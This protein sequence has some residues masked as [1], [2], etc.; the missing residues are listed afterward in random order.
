[1]TTSILD[2]FKVIPAERPPI[3]FDIPIYVN[4]DDKVKHFISEFRTS[5]KRTI[6]KTPI[7][8]DI[9]VVLELGEQ[10]LKSK[11]PLV[12]ITNVEPKKRDKAPAR[13]SLLTHM[14]FDE[15]LMQKYSYYT[16]KAA[17]KIHPMYLNNRINFINEIRRQMSTIQFDDDDD[18]GCFS[19]QKTS[20]KAMVHQLIVQRYLNSYTPYRGLLL[21]HG[22]GSGKTCSSISL[23][24]G[25]YNSKQIFIVTPASLQANY[26]TQMKFCGEQIF[27][28]NNHWVFEKIDSLDKKRSIYTLLNINTSSKKTDKFESFI[29]KHK[30][31]WMVDVEKEPNFDSLS[32]QNRELIDQQIELMI[33]AKY[34]YINYNGITRKSWTEKYKT[35]PDIN[36][37]DNSTIIIDEA[38]NFVSRIINKINKNGKSISTDLYEEILSA[39]NCRVVLLT[40][41]PFI[42][43]PSELG[44]LFNLINGYIYSM[45]VKLSI[46]NAKVKIDYFEKLFSDQKMIDIIEYNQNSSTLKIVKNPY[47]FIKTTDGK[48]IYNTDGNIYFKDFTQRIIDILKTKPED[49]SITKTSLTK[50]K[51]LPDTMKEF[52]SYFIKSDNTINNKEFF[53]RRIVGM[54]S[55][56][57]DKKELMP[58][59]EKT[60]KNED[61]FLESIVMSPHQLKTYAKIRE[62]ERKR[63]REQRGK[64]ESSS[65]YRVFSRLACN[66]AFPEEMPRPL[67]KGGKMDESAIDAA[68]EEELLNDADGKFDEEDVKNR[69]KTTL[70]IEYEQNIKYVLDEFQQ[71][72]EKYFE[73]GIQKYI[74]KPPSPPVLQ[75]YSPK[76]MEIL[77]N[78]MNPDPEFIGCHLLYSNFRKLEGIG[79]F[80][81]ILLYHGYRELKVVKNGTTLSLELIGMYN[82]DS[83]TD[84]K[85][86]ALYTGTETPE[87]KEIIRNIYN[88]NFK[89][90]PNTIQDN[91][92][93]LYPDVENGNLYGEIIQTIM[94]TASGAE[95]IDLKNTRFVH[96]MEPYWHHVR[97]NQ[98]I[99]RAR[100][101]CSHASL[102][103]NL[104]TV[105]VFMYLTE[106]GKLLDSDDY[107]ELKNSDDSLTTDQSLYNLMKRKEKLSTLFLDTLKEASIDCLVNYDNKDKCLHYPHSQINK[108]ITQLDYKNDAVTSYST[109]DKQGEKV[110]HTL[111]TRIIEVD[112]KRKPFAVDE[113]VKPNIA[114]DYVKYSV[115]K[116]LVEVGVVNV[117]N[118]KR[119]IKLN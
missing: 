50:Y 54:V 105:R 90:I 94:I 10:K 20:F 81:L 117:I 38:H 4:L 18:E 31:I 89:A 39:E 12:D 97:I 115:D 40:G 36:P 109:Q 63:E 96:I 80:R 60:E 61:I 33:L 26:R 57:G 44:V 79:I 37:F 55:Y 47:G 17:I 13:E 91:L 68:S 59:I 7:K 106:F 77:K 99:G 64:E 24:E 8:L 56:L 43:S 84:R 27:R 1:M 87:E 22:L 101:I 41:T 88:N 74:N 48:L 15:D 104:R 95:G 73:S 34:K 23:I 58:S 112:G 32:I 14:D 19:K 30:G 83:Y 65:T 62:D 85:V 46:K 119:Q 71:N 66:F 100:R 114:Y 35:S 110:K 45:D 113:T 3:E 107:V 108:L 6:I 103:E 21:Y 69:K 86:F 78:L 29:D 9:Q 53:Q 28:K 92:K 52:S 25:M 76:Y 116:I 49:F 67:P 2:I 42:N 111:V 51:K 5:L 75:T 98:V 93:Q 82:E 11:K 72:P 118:D 102:P 70:D 16:E